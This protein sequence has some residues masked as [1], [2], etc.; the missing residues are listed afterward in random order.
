MQQHYMFLGQHIPIH[1]YSSVF[2]IANVA[3]EVNCCDH[4][5]SRLSLMM[6][7]ANW[8]L[9]RMNAARHNVLDTDRNKQNLTW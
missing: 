4:F 2:L 9:I 8:N 5:L 1:E 6:F 3:Y 7:G